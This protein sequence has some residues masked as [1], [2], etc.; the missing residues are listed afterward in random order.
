MSSP[1]LERAI[2]IKSNPQRGGEIT[3]IHVHQVQVGEA[4]DSVVEIVLNYGNVT[5]GEFHPDLHGVSISQLTAASAPR[6]LNIFGN[7]GHP[8][9][10]VHLHACRFEQVEGPDEIRF[11][12]GLTLDQ[13]WANGERIDR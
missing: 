12:D 2:R 5:T 6:A 1:H 8:V 10:D 3:G 9:R 11:V 4:A 7:P 13:V